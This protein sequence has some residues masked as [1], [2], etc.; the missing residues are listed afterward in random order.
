MTTQ[1]PIAALE[2]APNPDLAAAFVGYVVSPSGQAVL[3]KWGFT[4]AAS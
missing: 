4:S 1:Y 2:K 3:K